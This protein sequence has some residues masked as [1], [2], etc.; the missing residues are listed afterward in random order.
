MGSRWRSP[1]FG[2]LP[3]PGETVTRS[4]T[5]GVTQRCCGPRQM[6][7][8][9]ATTA[10]GLRSKQADARRR[11]QREAPVSGPGPCAGVRGEAR[12]MLSG[13][14]RRHYSVA[15]APVPT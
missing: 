12:S 6:D 15:V 3:L 13:D 2:E 9:R 1:A 11:P 5:R 14:G 10:G 7:R 8:C 4:F